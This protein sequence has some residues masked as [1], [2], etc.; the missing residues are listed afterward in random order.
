MPTSE[1]LIIGI[2]AAEIWQFSSQVPGRRPNEKKGIILEGTRE[3]GE[4]KGNKGRLRS[5]VFSQVVKNS[6]S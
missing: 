3:S 6:S 2:K 1:G 5:R 4:G